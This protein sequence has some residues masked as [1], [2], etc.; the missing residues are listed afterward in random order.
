VALLAEARARGLALEPDGRGGLVAVK[1]ELLELISSGAARQA[2]AADAWAASYRRLSV[3]AAD[4]PSGGFDLLHR[5]R[6]GL[7][8]EIN[9]AEAEGERAVV[10][11]RDGALG[12]EVFMGALQRWELLIAEAAVILARVCHDCGREAPIAMVAP[13]DRTRFCPA[14]MR[15]G[16]RE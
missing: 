5:L 8:R 14:C 11:Y 9:A 16:G 7:L 12:A 2:T 6:P 10:A 3:R 4:W 1:L 13:V 15:R